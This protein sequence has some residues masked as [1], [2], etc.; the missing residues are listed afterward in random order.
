VIENLKLKGQHIGIERTLGR[1]E[2]IAVENKIYLG[3]SDPRGFGAAV[4]Y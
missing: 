4:G 2:A 1:V 3:A